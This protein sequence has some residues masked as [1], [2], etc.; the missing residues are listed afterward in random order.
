MSTAN[1]T[2]SPYLWIS[3][4]VDNNLIGNTKWGQGESTFNVMVFTRKGLVKQVQRRVEAT[5]LWQ[6]GLDLHCH[7]ALWKLKETGLGLFP[8]VFRDADALI[9][10]LGLRCQVCGHLLWQTSIKST[11]EWSLNLASDTS[12]NIPLWV[13]NRW[14]VSVFSALC[15]KVRCRIRIAETTQPWKFAGPDGC[16]IF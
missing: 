12:S 8:G 3:L 11:P 6:Q 13:L 4:L 7:K 14:Q 9:L 10:C 15:A 2:M 16:S 1:L 5:W